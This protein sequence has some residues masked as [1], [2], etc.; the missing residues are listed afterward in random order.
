M[1]PGLE[2]V[3][4][5]C[6]DK[7]TDSEDSFVWPLVQ[8]FKVGD[9]YILPQQ[10]GQPIK[11]IKIPVGRTKNIGKRQLNRL[12]D[13]ILRISKS[14]TP[15]IATLLS[16]VIRRSN[17]QKEILTMSKVKFAKKINPL[18][19]R[20]NL[21]LSNHQFKIMTQDLRSEGS[22]VQSFKWC[23]KQLKKIE[24]RFTLLSLV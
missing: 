10:K 3:S 16:A 17:R 11:L 22:D 13:M 18:H 19:I 14:V 8:K 23:E 4:D 1:S 21:R 2:K 5:P 6:S 7:G 9:A 24:G 15:D 20:K 12:A